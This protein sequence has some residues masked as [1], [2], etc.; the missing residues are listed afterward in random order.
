MLQARKIIDDNNLDFQ[1][2]LDNHQVTIEAPANDFDIDTYVCHKAGVA[3]TNKFMASL[4]IDDDPDHPIFPLF[5][6][7][8]YWNN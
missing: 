5:N 2:M 8:N 7:D 1:E 4:C 3:G 6:P